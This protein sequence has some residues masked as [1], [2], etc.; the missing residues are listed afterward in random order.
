VIEY[1]LLAVQ[2]WEPRYLEKHIDIL[3]QYL[4]HM[5][6]DADSV[7]RATARHVFWAFHNHFPGEAER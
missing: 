2:T 4:V 1:I 6:N 7:A 5:L 3:T